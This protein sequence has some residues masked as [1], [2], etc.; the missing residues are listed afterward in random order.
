[1]DREES[2][3]R[4]R[5]I[6]VARSRVDVRGSSFAP[7]PTPPKRPDEGHAS[8]RFALG[9][10]W[11]DGRPFVEA[12]IRPSL[13]DLVDPEGGYTRGAEI[14]FLDVAARYYPAE[15]RVRL[16]EAVLLDMVSL[17]PWDGFFRP[18]SFRFDTGLRTRLLPDGGGGSDLDPDPVWRTQ[19][20]LGLAFDLGGAGLAYGMGEAIADVGPDLDDHFALGGGAS[21]GLFVG[22]PGDRWRGHLFGRVTRFALGDRSTAVRAGL[23][24]RLTLTRNTALKAT[25]A[26]ERDFG[27]SW[28]DAVVTWNLYF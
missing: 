28:F 11:E 20:G 5:R 12:R 15:Q 27:E 10:G 23:E 16:H 7:V 17:A 22:T 8:A 19:G 1:V 6:L 14:Q 9:G 3:Q 25:T 26:F 4:S 21:L 2:R 18:V 24:Q 13:H